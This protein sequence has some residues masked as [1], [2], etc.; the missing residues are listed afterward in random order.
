MPNQNHRNVCNTVVA[1]NLCIGC[2]LCAAICPHE[3]LKI[4]F[5]EYG[6]YHTTLSGVC[7]N[8]CGLCLSVCPFFDQAQNE[9]TLANKLF[10]GV[11]GI[12]YTPETGYYLDAFVGHSNITSHR[13]NGASGG[14]ATWML[15]T[16]LR[17]NLVDY[18]AC[19]SPTNEQKKLFRFVVA[20]KPEDVRACSSSCYYP[21]EINN[22]VRHILS[23]NGRYAIIGLP[24]F[25]KAIRLAMQLKPELQ[26]RVKYLLGLVCGQ[27]KSKFFAE[28]IC[29]MGGGDPDLLDRVRFRV[30]EPSRPASDYGMEFVCGAGTEMVSEGVVFWSEG[31]NQVWSDR[32]FTPNAC[33]F[34]DDVFA[35][36][37]DVCFM[38]AWLPEYSSD[39]KGHTIVLVRKDSL[40]DVLNESAENGSISLKNL[41]ISKVVESQMGAL[42][43]KRAGI[44]ERIRLAKKQGCVVPTKRLSLCN[45]S[46]SSSEKRL[47]CAQ[48][49]AS[50]ESRKKWIVAKKQLPSFLVELKP[51]LVWLRRA[52]F[53]GKILRLPHR[54][55]R[56]LKRALV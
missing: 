21:V 2:G 24:C 1:N 15:E 17:K 36:V 54:I 43:S 29:S 31:I 25:C 10:A 39:W 4:D 13:E 7:P 30:K 55:I 44:R 46:L 3:N 38:D 37:A 41:D 33:N 11:R 34:C 20:R 18:A 5:N 51:Q 56:L 12:K 9:D 32:Y 16:L 52:R 45:I 40:L 50:Q 27:T 35:E 19:V 42:R 6:E 47:V 26:H 22:V 8:T 48:Y 28:Y 53:L 23:H 49:L 14:I